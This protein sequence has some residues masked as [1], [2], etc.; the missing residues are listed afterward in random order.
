M[1]GWTVKMR[2]LP[3]DS[4]TDDATTSA[5]RRDFAN[6]PLPT[7]RSTNDQ[8]PDGETG[9]KSKTLFGQDKLPEQDL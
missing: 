6:L 2:F 3:V 1:G 9:G 8:G 4:R 5:N 7:Q